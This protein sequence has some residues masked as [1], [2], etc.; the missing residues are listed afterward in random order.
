MQKTLPSKKIVVV[1]DT[2][3]IYSSVVR[4]LHDFGCEIVEKML[5]LGDYVCSE[6]ICVERKT[7]EDFTASIIDGRLFDQIA[8]L[9][10]SYEKP[11]LIIEGRNFFAR[12]VHP[13]AVY[14]ALASCVELGVSLLH[15]SNPRETAKIIYFLA[16]K[17]QVNGR[18]EIAFK[19]KLK[20]KSLQ[21]FQLALI[22]S[23]PFVNTTLAKRLLKYFKTPKAIFS[24]SEREL[25]KVEGIG[26][27]KARAIWKVLN[28]EW[29]EES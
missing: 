26:E 18:R 16:K 20:P 21:E 1:V 28:K 29:E 23:L 7:A 14:G 4:E 11:V 17:E 22:A 3:E 5:P 24:A 15:S 27:R 13:N 9:K 10:E 6:R 19:T 8:R 12:G 2:R 25:R